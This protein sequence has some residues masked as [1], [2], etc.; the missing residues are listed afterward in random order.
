MMTQNKKSSFRTTWVTQSVVGDDVDLK[1][2]LKYLIPYPD[3]VSHVYTLLFST[4]SRDE[5]KG[6]I[7]VVGSRSKVMSNSFFKVQNF[8]V[9]SKNFGLTKVCKGFSCK[10]KPTKNDLEVHDSCLQNN[11]YSYSPFPGNLR[12][13]KC[14]VLVSTDVK[15]DE[16]EDA[17][18]GLLKKIQSK[19]ALNVLYVRRSIS[20][21][22]IATI[23]LTPLLPFGTEYVVAMAHPSTNLMS[24]S[25]GLSGSQNY[26]AP[27][28]S[29]IYLVAAASNTT[30]WFTFSVNKG[31]SNGSM[32]DFMA[33]QVF[34]NGFEMHVQRQRAKVVLQAFENVRVRAEYDL[35]GTLIWSGRPVV[36]FAGTREVSG[37]CQ[38]LCQSGRANIDIRAI[39]DERRDCCYSMAGGIVWKLVQSPLV[40]I[41]AFYFGIVLLLTI[42][43]N[44]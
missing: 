36:V 34:V 14:S 35:T 32:G 15:D 10:R 7:K 37:L 9:R 21:P 28:G 11:L 16:E 26:G 41:S 23:G 1:H 22:Q 40:G 30:V 19:H 8:L 2:D 3:D 25:D 4:S 17:S 42:D 24:P 44:E 38:R 43:V 39:S 18:N 12:V 5:V 29:E 13:N 31:N 6:H 27:I 20:R 33:A